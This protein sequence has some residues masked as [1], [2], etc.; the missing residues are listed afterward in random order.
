MF[1]RKS[2]ET[3]NTIPRWKKGATEATA[4]V[5]VGLAALSLSACG[6]KANA[7]GPTPSEMSTSQEL[8]TNSASTIDTQGLETGAVSVPDTSETA[9][10]DQE[11]TIYTPKPLD[12]SSPENLLA[13]FQYDMNC[14]LNAEH[15]VAVDCIGQV[16]GWD[17]NTAEGKAAGG[18]LLKKLMGLSNQADARRM[19]GDSGYKEDEQYDLKKTYMEGKFLVLE[20]NYTNI[21]PQDGKTEK[22]I[23]AQFYTDTAGVTTLYGYQTTFPSY[24]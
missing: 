18:E 1:S 11:K 22:Y 24:S 4:F 13:S 12:A 21:N 5:A 3:Q 23:K 8:S 10:P 6:E 17:P 15:G 19:F 14:M 20:Y 9:G 7:T 16:L 2:A